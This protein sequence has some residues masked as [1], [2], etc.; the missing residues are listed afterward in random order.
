PPDIPT[1]PSQPSGEATDS[2]HARV[3][4]QPPESIATNTIDSGISYQVATLPMCQ[5]RIGD[6]AEVDYLPF[7]YGNSTSEG[8]HEDAVVGS[9]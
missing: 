1:A 7:N 6:G 8:A 5:F 4:Q 2:A 3:R 9:F